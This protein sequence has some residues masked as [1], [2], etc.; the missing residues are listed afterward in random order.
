MRGIASDTKGNIYVAEG[1]LGH[2]QLASSSQQRS[3]D[4]LRS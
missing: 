2:R 1:I 3:L 4:V